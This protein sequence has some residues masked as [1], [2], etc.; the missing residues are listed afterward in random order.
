MPSGGIYYNGTC[1]YY[2]V[3]KRLCLKINFYE[4]LNEEADSP[5]YF[6]AGCFAKDEAS[7]FHSSQVGKYYDFSREVSVEV[8]ATEDPY[9]V[10][11]YTRDSLGTDF[12]L[13]L[14]LAI[15][16]AV[17]CGFMIISILYFFCF[18]FERDE[19]PV[20]LK[21]EI[22]DGDRSGRG[23]SKSALEHRAQSSNHLERK[24]NALRKDASHN[25]VEFRQ[26]QRNELM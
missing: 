8:R 4:L 18:V 25:N 26:Y 15:F 16:C 11:A 22:R 14:Y 6:D 10:F 21:G 2:D 19:E 5:I 20:F 9:M 13:F 3:L 12:T 17:V 24:H 23:Q 1:H 7:L